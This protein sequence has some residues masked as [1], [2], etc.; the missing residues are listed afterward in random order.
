VPEAFDAVIFDYGGVLATSP[1]GRLA[2][3]EAALGLA[4]GTVA[5]LLGYGLDVAEPAPGEPY[6]NKWHLLEIG[7]VDIDEYRA[8]V[9]ERA[10]AMFGRPVDVGTRMGGSLSTMGVLW[11]MVHEARRL[12]ALGYRLAVCTNNIAAYRDEWR[13]QLPLELFDVVVDSH[14]VGLRKPEPAIYALTCDRLGVAPERCV[15][16]DDHPG[17]VAA[18]EAVGMAGVLV[19]GDDVVAA[20]EHLHRLLHGVST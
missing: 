14:E 2:E 4:P 10:A 16:V 18:A 6:T 9:A 12:R 20:I 7:A 3:L 8:W 13:A 15:F 11:P 5:D 17:N 1:F 19:R